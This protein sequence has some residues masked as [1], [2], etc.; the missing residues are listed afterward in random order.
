M[1][2]EMKDKGKGGKDRVKEMEKE[3]QK[4]M[5]KTNVKAPEDYPEADGDTKKDVPPGT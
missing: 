4:K 1:P 5:E 2:T 3:Q